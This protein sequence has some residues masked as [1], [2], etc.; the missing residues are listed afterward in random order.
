MFFARKLMSL[1]YFFIAIASFVCVAVPA[2]AEVRDFYIVT[3]HY[4]GKTNAKGDATHKPEPFPAK[5]FESGQGMWVKGPEANGDWAVRAFVFDPSH[6]TVMQ[7]DD[8]RLHFVGIHGGS[9]QISVEGVENPV[10][11]K[12]GTTMTVSFK[13]AKPGIVTFVCTDHPPS[14]RGQVVVLARN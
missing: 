7:G 12:R 14:M 5:P 3:V 11:V 4:D 6:V 2:S 9:H 13:A 8:V 1:A 10:T